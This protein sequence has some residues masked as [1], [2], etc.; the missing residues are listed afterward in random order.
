MAIIHK[1]PACLNDLVNFREP[2]NTERKQHL[3]RRKEKVAKHQMRRCQS[4]FAKNIKRQP[5]HEIRK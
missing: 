3:L 1:N 4:V 2:A 5:N